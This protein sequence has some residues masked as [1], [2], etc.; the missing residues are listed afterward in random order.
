MI[1]H[2]WKCDP[3]STIHCPNIGSMLNI[4]P[5]LGQYV[6]LGGD[7]LPREGSQKDPEAFVHTIHTPCRF[8]RTSHGQCH[9]LAPEGRI[10]HFSKWQIR[11]S[12]AKVTTWKYGSLSNTTLSGSTRLWSCSPTSDDTLCRI[13]RWLNGGLF[14]DEILQ[15]DYPGGANCQ[16]LLTGMSTQGEWTGR[17]RGGIVNTLDLFVAWIFEDD[18]RTVSET[19]ST[20]RSPGVYWMPAVFID[21]IPC[22]VPQ[23]RACDALKITMLTNDIIAAISVNSSSIWTF[24]RHHH[25]HYCVR[26]W[27]HLCISMSAQYIGYRKRKLEHKSLLLQ[28]PCMCMMSIHSVAHPIH[29]NSL[30]KKLFKDTNLTITQW[31]WYIYIY[32]TSLHG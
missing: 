22:K 26:L 18:S 13:R 11:P 9:L 27:R 29:S 19:L 5:T 21:A 8:N 4:E 32:S 17:I 14:W 2:V 6:V 24:C 15:I 30:E 1:G 16:L 23:S 31:K 10:C 3:A 28:I 12:G 25:A 7:I 20:R